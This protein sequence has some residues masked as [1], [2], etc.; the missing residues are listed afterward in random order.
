M[1][2]LQRLAGMVCLTDKQAPSIQ[3]WHLERADADRADVNDWDCVEK[4]KE[5]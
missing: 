5:E 2:N 3:L 1:R 4:Y